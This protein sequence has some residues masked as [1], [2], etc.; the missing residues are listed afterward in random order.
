ME[1][2][3]NTSIIRLFRRAGIKSLSKNSFIMIKKIIHQKLEEII[4]ISI[5]FNSTHNK[6]IISSNDIY[7]TM[8]M[9][10]YNVSELNI[11][12]KYSFEVYINKLLSQVFLKNE[13]THNAKSQLNSVLSIICKHILRSIDK[14]TINPKD[15]TC[16]LYTFLSG[17]LLK[18][19][20]S[21]GEKAVNNFTNFEKTT[22]QKRASKQQKADIIFSPSIIDKIFKNENKITISA[23][24]FIAAIL[25]YLA[26]E[27]L[28][29]S[30][31]FCK[32]ND[33]SRITIRDMELA[34]RTDIEL[35]KLFN[36]LN[37]LFLGGGVIPIIANP[38]KIQNH[39]N[40]KIKKEQENNSLIFSKTL[41]Q[42]LVRSIYNNKKINKEVFDILQYIIEQYCIDILQKA[43]CITINSNR[44]RLIPNDINIVYHIN[45]DN[46]INNINLSQPIH[47]T[48]NNHFEY[49]FE[50]N[51]NNE[52][53]DEDEYVDIYN[54]SEIT[55]ED[56]GLDISGI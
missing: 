45:N 44:I 24:I 35:N 23:K 27:I 50:I 36:K 9:L 11:D 37:I 52:Y 42:K 39:I 43:N 32:N 48:Q 18:N 6:K 56:I 41:F 19:S 10:G 21:E 28:D 2:L 38:E 15:I 31:I 8:E 17:E 5:N 47:H 25:E 33:R 49:L 13:I 54:D 1:F 53:T 30:I 34:V 26:Y 7:K 16:V 3:K 40:K 4:I 22:D 51:D 46:I 20:I 29:L 55:D 12:K 14:K